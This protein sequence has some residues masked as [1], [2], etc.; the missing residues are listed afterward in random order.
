MGVIRVAVF[1]EDVT[2]WKD[3]ND[4]EKWPQDRA[5]EH[6]GRNR[7]RVRFVGFE[8][9]ELC[10]TREIGREPEEGGVSNANG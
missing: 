1:A 8:L 5:L 4:E 3:V 9:N 7:E 2:E 6:T 10:A